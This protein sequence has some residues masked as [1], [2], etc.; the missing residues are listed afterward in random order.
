M[1][2]R[3]SNNA[4]QHMQTSAENRFNP[5]RYYLSDEAKKRL[6]WMYLL[7][8]EH[9]NNVTRA[10]DKIGI[11]RQWLSTIKSTFDHHRKDP[12][13][14]EPRSRA[15]HHTTNRKRISKEHEQ[16][17]LEVRDATPG[18]GEEK[19]A[20]LVLRDHS[21]K[22]GHTTVGRYLKKHGKI[23]SKISD[24]NHAAWMRKLARENSSAAQP[25]L[26][27][28]HRPP[29]AIKDYAPG[30]LIEKDMKFIVKQGQ[31]VNTA[32]YK[33][34]ENFFYQHTLID[35]FTRMR[36][37]ALVKDAE[38]ATASRA[39][40]TALKRFPFPVACE[41]TDNGSENNGAFSKEL[42]AQEVFQFYSSV[43]TP[44]D[45][46]R[47]ERSHLTDDK[48]FYL[49][50]NMFLPFK[51]QSAQLMKWERRYNNER[52]HQA[53][54]YL[55]P[56]EFYQ[57]WKRSPQEAHDIVSRWQNYLARQRKRLYAT[58]RIKRKEQ[59]E[60][61]MR[62]VDAK[63]NKKVELQTAKQALIDCQLCSWG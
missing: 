22:V 50:G 24:K 43:G 27:V 11:S 44:T 18:W 58:R 30:A 40:R 51:E 35:S 8:H 46:P 14:L 28:K 21:I 54:G 56:M 47:V 5:L 41:N 33:A 61:L 13:S 2:E 53:L 4:F 3:L 38:S 9:E 17:I 55:T 23:D 34:K 7:Y 57:L 52:P 59:V 42:A 63:L 31:F 60:N 45:N 19:I 29:K 6:K 32:K 39:H 15:P 26:K 12:R 25:T 49:R 48:E 37:L 1:L 62:F 20:T 36:A 16:I 10:A